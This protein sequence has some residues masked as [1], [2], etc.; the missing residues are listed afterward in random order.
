MRYYL[1]T[2][3]D[4]H[5]GVLLSFALVRDDGRSVHYRTGIRAMDLW[6]IR[7]V[8]PLMDT[9]QADE[10]G[11]LD[12]PYFAGTVIRDFIG[13]DL[14]PVIVADSPV[15]IGRFCE[16]ISTGPDGG[17]ASAEYPQMTFEVHNVDCYPT[18]L[19]GAVQHNAWW[20]A[21]ALRHKLQSP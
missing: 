7:N 15:D 12:G 11:T 19:P 13:E 17:W 14:S 10:S 20:D 9:H 3:F 16:A 8:E 5:G 4:G 1:D 2:E 21:M 18:T 6:V